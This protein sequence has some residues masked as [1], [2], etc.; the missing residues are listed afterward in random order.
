M[1][2]RQRARMTRK[3]GGEWGTE[4]RRDG[5]TERQ[6][7]GSDFSLCLSVSLSLRPSVPPSPF[8]FWFLFAFYRLT[9]DVS[10]PQVYWVERQIGNDRPG[11]GDHLQ[12]ESIASSRLAAVDD[13]GAERV[14]RDAVDRR[15][16]GDH[17]RITDNRERLH[18]AGLERHKASRAAFGVNQSALWRTVLLVLDIEHEGTVPAV[19]DDC[20]Y[21]LEGPERRIKDRE[22]SGAG[23]G[24]IVPANANTHIIDV[25]RNVV[26]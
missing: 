20:A 10:A 13:R 11:R 19:V 4:G 2:R 22:R 8:P 5:G 21:A 9:P 25:H 17:P 18:G 24:I 16:A 1:R 3:G 26:Q 12:A 23:A 14:V 6:R 15:F 7:D